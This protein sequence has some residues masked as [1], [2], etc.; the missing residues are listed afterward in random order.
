MLRIHPALLVLPALAAPLAFAATPAKQATVANLYLFVSPD[1]PIANRYATRYT[2]LQRDYAGRGVAITL[3]Y[4]GGDAA[5]GDAAFAKWAKTRNLQALTRVRDTDGSLAKRLHATTT[6][7]AILTDAAGEIK[8]M[9]RIDDNADTTLVT[10]SDARDAM[11]AVING[12]PVT[13]TRTQAFGCAIELPTL[14]AKV[15][16]AAGVTYAREVAPILNKNCVSCHREGDAG[17]FLL[18]NYKSAKQWSSAIKSYTAARK[19]PPFKA[20]PHFGGPFDDQRVLSEKE[21]ATLAAWHDAGAPSGNLK[22]A[23]RPPAPRTSEWELG[24]PNA[25]VTPSRA[26]TLDADGGDVY[27]DFAVGETFTE[28]T[29]VK[30]MEFL[31]SNRAVVHHMIM[32]IDLTGATV[33]EKEGKS[34]DGQPGWQVSGAGSG[35]KTWDWGAGWAP[36][37]NA[38]LLRPGMAVKVPK[39]ARL[40]LQVHYHKSGKP[41]TDRPRVALHYAKPTEKITDI[42]RVAALGNPLLRLKPNVADNEV[43][44]AMILPYDATVH[45]VLPH[46]HYLGKTM[47]VTALTP[48]GE[49]IPIVKITDWE[50]NWQMTYR[51][52]KPIRLPKGTRLNLVATYDNTADN[53]FQPSQPPIEV[54]FGEETTDEM[55]FAFIGLTRDKPASTVAALPK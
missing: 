33:A 11:N 3:V 46:M 39:G 35:V 29:Y 2:A 23:P 31:P 43:K 34:P 14:A 22:T 44:A 10:R 1:C 37:M 15:P 38:A 30:A 25:V 27:R 9:G 51:Y 19:M 50:F 41:E 36:G 18:D 6:P 45:N 48:T 13:K 40:V 53:P 42:L 24:T 8:Y 5:F 55:C 52:Q 7:Q 47:T 49:T 21:I 17:P 20:D 28:D 16:G 12:K 32:Y 54:G 26:Y 4:S